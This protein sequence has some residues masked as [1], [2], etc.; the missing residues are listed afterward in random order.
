MARGL[1]PWGPI[2]TMRWLSTDYELLDRWR[3]GDAEAGNDLFRRHFSAVYR[4]FRDKVHGEADE[5]IQATF[6]AC[7]RA[8][9]QFRKDCSF[10]AFL[11]TLARHE[12]Y[13]YFRHKASS[14]DLDFSV[15]SLADMGPSPS[16]L[17][18]LDQRRARLV[19]AVRRLPLQQQLLI[20]LHYWED[21]RPAE[22]AQ[23]FEIAEPTARV[24]L[25]RARKAL[26][27]QLENSG[28][29]PTQEPEADDLD[30]WVQDIR[31]QGRD[32]GEEHGA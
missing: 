20:E 26:R 5:L 25:F 10:R 15:T 11:F 32:S 23:V 30:A 28:A 22:L 17:L 29:A 19:R 14:A 7:V 21:M 24:W 18:E 8:R 2:G 6:L 12:L 13:R 31:Q 1:Q 27:T 9:D 3:D 4:F 16:R